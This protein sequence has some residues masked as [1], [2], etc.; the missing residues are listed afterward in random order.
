MVAAL[1]FHGEADLA[2]VEKKRLAR[3]HRVEDRRMGQVGARR[4]A[5][6]L[7]GVE[8]EARA[9]VEHG[10]A[11]LHL[12]DPELRPLQI[13]ENADRPLHLALHLPHGGVYPLQVLVVE[14]AHVEPEDVRARVEE[15]ADH[16]GIV[17]SGAQ[18][19]DDLDVAAAGQRGE[20]LSS[21]G[22]L[23]VG[24]SGPSTSM[25]RKSFT[26]V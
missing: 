5:R 21:S 2:V 8:A 23:S 3:A 9:L 25:T 7:R 4:V 22:T 20:L 1:A 24:A 14:M 15:L 17:G 26:F 13:G 12:A 11:V 6:L 19:G 10:A 18:C 16:V